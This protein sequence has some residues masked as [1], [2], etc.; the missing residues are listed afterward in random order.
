MTTRRPRCAGTADRPPRTTCFRWTGPTS[1]ICG[2]DFEWGDAARRLRWSRAKRA[3]SPGRGR[4]TTPIGISACRSS[5]GGSHVAPAGPG[6][7]ADWAE[8]EDEH[9]LTH[10][11][12]FVPETDLERVAD[13]HVRIR[14]GTWSGDLRY[15]TPGTLTLETAWYC[16]D[17]GVRHR[18]PV[19]RYERTA[20]LPGV[21]VA[22][23][24]WDE[25]IGT[26]SLSSG[27]DETAEVLWK[28]GDEHLS[29]SPTRLVCR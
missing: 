8:G 7:V 18:A 27:S 24:A 28:S 1:A 17:F 19:I 20:S 25:S 13:R 29:W 2:H 6:F 9:R 16:P 23:L 14:R 11:L 10:W 15:L 26:V 4:R 21:F 12:H 5:A 22:V 3:T